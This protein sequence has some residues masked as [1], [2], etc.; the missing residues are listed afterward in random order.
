MEYDGYAVF[1]DSW[2]NTKPDPRTASPRVQQVRVNG[3]INW[4]VIWLACI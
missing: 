1:I 3:T 4:D 2:Q